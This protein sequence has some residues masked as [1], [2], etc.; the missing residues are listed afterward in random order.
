MRLNEKT[1]GQ[2][3]LAKLESL[4]SLRR[5]KTSENPPHMDTGFREG[6]R[7]RVVEGVLAG[8]EGVVLR[9]CGRSRVHLMVNV[10]GQDAEVEIDAANLEPL[11]AI[12][13]GI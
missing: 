8:L 7:V 3:L 12:K 11:E 5:T 10:M 9:P 2:T 13:A 4:P 1:N 6:S